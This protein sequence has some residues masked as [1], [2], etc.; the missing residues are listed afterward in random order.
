MNNLIKFIVVCCLLLATACRNDPAPSTDVCAVM[1]RGQASGTG[2]S[3]PSKPEEILRR[4]EKDVAELKEG[5]RLRQYLACLQQQ[6]L[7]G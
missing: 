1:M 3:M 4:L 5:D 2:A 7:D 6:R